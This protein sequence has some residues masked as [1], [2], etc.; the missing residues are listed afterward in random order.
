MFE[1]RLET[2]HCGAKCF[3]IYGGE[4]ILIDF[5]EYLKKHTTFPLDVRVIAGRDHLGRVKIAITGGTIEHL[6]FDAFRCQFM[7][8]YHN[9]R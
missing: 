6:S 4:D 2:L 8:G 3:A 9:S 7:D 5:V 1:G